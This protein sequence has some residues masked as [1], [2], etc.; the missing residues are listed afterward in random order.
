MVI[1]CT[2]VYKYIS[3]G[4]IPDMGQQRNFIAHTML[5]IVLTIKTT[6]NVHNESEEGKEVGGGWSEN[7]KCIL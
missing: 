1:V 7:K 5:A 4:D 3:S 6:D 2:D